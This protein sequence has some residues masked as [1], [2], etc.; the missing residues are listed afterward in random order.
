MTAAC[1]KEKL[2]KTGISVLAD[3]LEEYEPVGVKGWV[4][5]LHIA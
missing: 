3:C 1:P 2:S 5:I 4:W